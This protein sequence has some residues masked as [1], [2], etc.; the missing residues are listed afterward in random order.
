MKLRYKWN[1]GE[2]D[3]LKRNDLGGKRGLFIK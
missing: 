2:R 1:F 3:N